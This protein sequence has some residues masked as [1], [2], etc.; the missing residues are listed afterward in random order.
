MSSAAAVARDDL[1]HHHLLS[2]FAPSARSRAVRPSS[3]PR[4]PLAGIDLA[5]EAVIDGRVARGVHDGTAYV[6]LLDPAGSFVAE[7]PADADGGFRFFASPGT[8]TLRVQTAS[9][10][11][12]IEVDAV[13]GEVAHVV[14]TA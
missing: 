4:A 1:A 3:P 8:W 11:V 14:V 12:Q 6:R 5:R 2:L 7:V 13:Q 9:R 10:T